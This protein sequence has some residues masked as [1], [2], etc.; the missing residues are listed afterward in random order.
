MSQHFECCMCCKPPKRHP[1]CHAECTEYIEAREKYND[2][3]TSKIQEA[4]S[5]D[6]YMRIVQDKHMY[7]RKKRV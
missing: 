4:I 6:N 3:K 7:K 5:I 1:G 2:S